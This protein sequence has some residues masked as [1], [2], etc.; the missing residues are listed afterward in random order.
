MKKIVKIFSI[1]FLA[2]GLFLWV[3]PPNWVIDSKSSLS[4][5]PWWSFH[6]PIGKPLPYC[7]SVLDK[8]FAIR[9]MLPLEDCKLQDEIKSYYKKHLPKE[10]Q[11][12]L[13]SS[14]NLHNPTL[15]PLIKSFEKAFKETSL[16]KKMDKTLK[17]SG[18][19]L[20]DEISFEKFMIFKDKS[21][22]SYLFHADI[23]LYAKSKKD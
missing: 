15:K 5:N 12:A 17:V 13:K 11:K 14:A 8:S 19:K 10:L 4:Y 9:V 21:K 1:I 23:W 7:L 3:Y 6:S 16:Y 22:N 20:K 18:Y 2:G